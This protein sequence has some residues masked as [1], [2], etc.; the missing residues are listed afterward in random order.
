MRVRQGPRQQY[1]LGQ[2]YLHQEQQ[3]VTQGLL[4]QVVMS[5]RQQHTLQ[6]LQGYNHRFNQQQQQGSK[7][8]GYLP[9]GCWVL[10][11]TVG[12]LCNQFP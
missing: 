5:R 7:G 2:G 12:N 3:Q 11:A 4:S 6:Q 9:L 10:R 8:Q 1:N